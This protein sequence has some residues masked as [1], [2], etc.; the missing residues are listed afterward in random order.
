M[1][2]LYDIILFGGEGDLSLRKLMPALYRAECNQELDPDLR[3]ITTILANLVNRD[4]FLNKV[5]QGLAKQL[6]AKEFNPGHW[7]TFSH[8]I[9]PVALDI[10]DTNKGWTDL[11]ELISQSN[12]HS[13]FY[14]AIAP[15]LFSVACDH[16]AAQQLI[17]AESRVILEKPIGYDRESA[18]KINDSVGTYFPEENIYRIDHYL[19]KETV[20]N[21]MV[22]RFSN[23]LFEHLWD[24][25]SIDHVQITLAETVGLE[26]R[27]S[28]YDKAG[29]VRDMVQNHLLQLLCLVAM[30]PASE[31]C[32]DVIRNEKIKVLK[33][34]RPITG[35]SIE[36]NT[37]RGQYAFGVVNGKEQLGYVDELG[38]DSK[39]ETFVAIRAHIDNWRWAGV[40]FYLR[41]GKCMQKQFSEIAIQF[42]PVSHK[43]FGPQAGHIASNKLIVRLQPD[44]NIQL[45][46]MTKDLDRNDVHLEKV[47]LNLNQGVPQHN[48]DRDAY[49]RLLLD[50]LRGDSTLFIHRDEVDVSWQWL[51][52]ILD[53]WKNSDKQ[54]YQYAAGTWGP[55]E[56]DGLLQ[57][58][59]FK[60]RNVKNLLGGV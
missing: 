49:K 59:G 34:L 43:V 56:S 8:R 10:T 42:K 52:P 32:A 45:Q 15:S 18:Q 40:P 39:I 1:S 2:Q 35:D 36:Q 27:A 21:L 51:D 50:G 11:T 19:G 17:K 26:G 22:L 41:T 57:K 38:K 3:I 4:D 12:H 53:A 28:F 33:A 54:P 37:I 23:Y 44:E 47:S 5:K 25:K 58:D 55:Q 13:L 31:M 16:L 29:A 6:P 7:Q 30:E 46:L 14:F 20:Q 9:Y 48:T 24:A 60:W